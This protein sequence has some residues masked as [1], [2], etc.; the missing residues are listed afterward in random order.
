MAETDCFLSGLTHADIRLDRERFIAAWPDRKYSLDGPL[1]L[2][3]KEGSDVFVILAVIRYELVNDKVPQPK[4][5]NGI[6]RSI[7]KVKAVGTG[8]KI[9]SVMEA[10]QGGN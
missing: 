9:I 5:R 8:F 3:G 6:S 1:Q 4:R 2:L 7:Y 10:K